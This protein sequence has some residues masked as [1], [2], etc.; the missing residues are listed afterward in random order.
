MANT[1]EGRKPTSERTIA[2]YDNLIEALTEYL[3]S[4]SIDQ[5]DK[6][7]I[8]EYDSASFA[9]IAVMED[10]ENLGRRL[11]PVGDNEL[12]R[13]IAL[14]IGDELEPEEKVRLASGKDVG[15]LVALEVL[16]STSKNW[17]DIMGSGMRVNSEAKMLTELD[18]MKELVKDILERNGRP[19]VQ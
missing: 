2:A 12:H 17:Q 1:K 10:E 11:F 14:S 3:T 9:V 16:E 13:A 5:G 8:D 18:G 19:S 7:C 4:Q 15:P 6:R